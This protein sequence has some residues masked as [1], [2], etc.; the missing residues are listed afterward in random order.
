MNDS[1]EQ[2]LFNDR[3]ETITPF[4]QHLSVTRAKA[5]KRFVGLFKVGPPF[6]RFAVLSQQN[7]IKVRSHSRAVSLSFSGLDTMASG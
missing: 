6:E 7:D 4:L 5:T 3:N 2:Y 1:P